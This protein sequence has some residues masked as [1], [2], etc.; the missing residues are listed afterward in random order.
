[1]LR[2]AL[3]GLG[4]LLRANESGPVEMRLSDWRGR[5]L[6]SV[7]PAIVRST[8]ARKPPDRCELM[9]GWLRW[10]GRCGLV[11]PA[12]EAGSEREAAKVSVEGLDGDLLRGALI[13]SCT[14]SGD[15]DELDGFDVAA[16]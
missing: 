10:C 13:G 8:K 6:G 9:D 5:I 16:I 7:I 11:E 1:M 14:V 4:W 2:R 3:S 15:G 12:M